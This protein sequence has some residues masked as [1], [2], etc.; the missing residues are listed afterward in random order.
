MEPF[1]NNVAYLLD[2]KE[3]ESRFEPLLFSLPKQEQ[4][5]IL[6]FVRPQDQMTSLGKFLLLHRYTPDAPL[7]KRENGKP[8]KEMGPHF[9]IS[10]CYPYVV[11]FLLDSS[12]GVDI[13]VNDEKRVSFLLDYFDESKEEGDFPA[14]LRWTIKESCYKAKGVG[15]LQPKAPL[16]SISEDLLEYDGDVYHFHCFEIE[17]AYLSFAST[18]KFDRPLIISCEI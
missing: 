6:K 11:L 17:D 7:L 9:S 3:I 18:I 10:H 12:C 4:E 8:Y 2:V 16:L 15:Y 1:S 13:E 14:L 5:A